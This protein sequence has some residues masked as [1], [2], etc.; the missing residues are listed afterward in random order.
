MLSLLTNLWLIATTP[1]PPQNGALNARRLGTVGR[2]TNER[3][4]CHLKRSELV[5][6]FPPKLR[7]KRNTTRHKKSFFSFAVFNV[8]HVCRCSQFSLSSLEKINPSSCR[9]NASVLILFHSRCTWRNNL[10]KLSE[11]KWINILVWLQMELMKTSNINIFCIIYIKVYP[12][13]FQ[14]IFAGG[15]C[16]T[17]KNIPF[18]PSTAP[19][20]HT[21]TSHPLPPTHT[22]SVGQEW[23]SVCS[24]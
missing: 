8:P 1:P 7:T 14:C 13:C 20:L 22:T 4:V 9:T 23:V 15:L 19:T 2:T 10:V 21:H 24:C 16:R 12:H 5:F 17:Y 18:R 3:H 11:F 6:L